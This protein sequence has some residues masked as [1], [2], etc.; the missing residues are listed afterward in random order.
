VSQGIKI[1][2]C[3]QLKTDVDV[4]NNSNKGKRPLGE[5]Y[6]QLAQIHGRRT[7]Q[8]FPSTCNLKPLRAVQTNREKRMR[9]FPDVLLFCV[10]PLTLL[11]ASL[12]A[13]EHGSAPHA[14]HGS[15][16]GGHIPPHGPPP[17]HAHAHPPSPG[18]PAHYSDL[19]GHPDVPHV[20]ANGK[21]VGHDSGRNDPAYHLDHPWE[22][23]HFT[24]GI[25]RGHVWRLAGGGPSRFWFG[26]FYFS[27]APA[28]LAFCSGWLWDSDQIVLYDDPDHA[29][30][31]LAYNVRLGTYAHVMYLGA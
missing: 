6:F 24:G 16:V 29:G 10:L 21:W 26:G 13:Q 2:D 17:A 23:G 1:G 25:G 30:W 3:A 19:P 9:R 8:K 5:G 28:D 18:Q 12:P 4:Y 15:D 14:P 31:Y 22:H 27:V 11:S 20:H 7:P